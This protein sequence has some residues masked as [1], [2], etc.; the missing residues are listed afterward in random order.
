[1]KRDIEHLIVEMLI[2]QSNLILDCV[3]GKREILDVTTHLVPC[4]ANKL[5]AL[6]V[7]LRKIIKR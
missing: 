1:M 4:K 6:R 3:E 2:E 5:D 7:R